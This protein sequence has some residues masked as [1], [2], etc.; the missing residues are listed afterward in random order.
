MFTFKSMKRVFR[1]PVMHSDFEKNGFVVVDFYTNESLNEVKSLYSEM[2][3][4]VQ[5]D[6]FPSAYSDD[7]NYRNTI[8]RELTRIGQPKFDELF[9]DYQVMNACFIVK[10]SGKDSYLHVHQDMTLVDESEYVGI[11]IWTTTID[12]T[13]ENGVLY[14][15]P[16][17]HRFLPTYRGHTLPGFYDPIQE[18]IK[19]YMQPLYLKAGQAIIFDQ[20]IVHFSPPNL[21]NDIRIVSNVFITH[22]DAKFQI[23][24]HDKNDSAYSGKVEI[25]EQDATFMTNYEQF[26]NEIYARPKQGKTLG[27]YDYNFPELTIEQLENK[28]DKV[29]LRFSTPTKIEKD[30]LQN[31]LPLWQIYSPLNILREVRFRIK[32]INKK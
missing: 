12:L 1:D 25:F 2:H 23:C 31:K 22:R 32:K 14:L 15:L 16:G 8:D 13:P 20:S 29:R 21:S 4:G 11:N 28:F 24:Y 19:D 30:I 27:F 10:Q 26:G 6:F 9:T 7:K 3:S 17:S 5:T 18:E